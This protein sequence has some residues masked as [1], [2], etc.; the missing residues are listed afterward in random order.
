MAK[1]VLRIKD[2]LKSKILNSI[3][4]KSTKKEKKQSPYDDPENEIDQE[5][6]VMQMSESIKDHYFT[7]QQKTELFTILYAA[8]VFKWF[9]TDRVILFFINYIINLDFNYSE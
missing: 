8:I 9:P 7:F 4:Q 6:K 1:K 2:R 5:D 3:K